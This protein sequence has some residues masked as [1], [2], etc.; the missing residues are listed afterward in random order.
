[1][2]FLVRCFYIYITNDIISKKVFPQIQEI[3]FY[4]LYYLP[5]HIYYSVHFIVDLN[6]C[7]CQY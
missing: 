6:V 4:L 2:L 3:P 1:M 5:N 7:Y